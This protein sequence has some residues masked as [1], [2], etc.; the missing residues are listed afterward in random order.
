[1]PGPPPRRPLQARRPGRPRPDRLVPPAVRELGPPPAA[2][3]AAQDVAALAG[4]RVPG[5]AVRRARVAAQPL[6]GAGRRARG[7][8]HPGLERDPLP[9]PVWRARAPEPEPACQEPTGCRQVPRVRQHY[10]FFLSPIRVFP[11]CFPSYRV[12]QDIS[13]LL[14]FLDNPVLVPSSTGECSKSLFRNSCSTGDPFRARPPHFYRRMLPFKRSPIFF[15][16][17]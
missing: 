13:G 4:D 5:R 10:V 9:P 17:Q 16:Y 2:A 3:A 14:T 7:H 12:C 8:A 15:F 11:K 1:M 6:V